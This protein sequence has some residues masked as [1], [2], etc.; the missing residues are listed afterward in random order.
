MV[1]WFPE[2][3][4]WKSDYQF[5]WDVKIPH[6]K[7]AGKLFCSSLSIFSALMDSSHNFAKA[8][9]LWINDKDF[10]KA[11]KNVVHGLRWLYFTR[12][13]LENGK[14]YDFTAGNDCW[15]EVPACSVSEGVNLILDHGMHGGGVGVLR[16]QVQANL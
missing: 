12:Q 6:L 9:R 4:V 11:K 3:C 10:R 14:V 16:E 15:L 2:S 1:N 8:K 13:I 7:R 5:K